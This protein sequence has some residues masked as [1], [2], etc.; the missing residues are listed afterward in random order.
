MTFHYAF[1]ECSMHKEH[2]INT[3]VNVPY[4]PLLN[5]LLSETVMK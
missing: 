3:L 2:I 4:L 1:T 5:E